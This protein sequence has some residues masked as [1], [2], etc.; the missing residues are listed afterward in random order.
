MSEHNCKHCYSKQKRSSSRHDN[1]CRIRQKIK[2]YVCPNANETFAIETL[3]SAIGIASK[4]AVLFDFVGM[5]V[6]GRYQGHVR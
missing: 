2:A 6:L 3:S 4:P 1:E 5:G